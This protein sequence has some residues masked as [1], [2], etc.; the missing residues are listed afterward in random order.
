[1]G[2]AELEM[3]IR[4]INAEIGRYNHDIENVIKPLIERLKQ[5]K[6]NIKEQYNKYKNKI[7]GDIGVIQNTIWYAQRKSTIYL[8]E[9]EINK[10][11]IDEYIRKIDDGISSADS[12]RMNTG[13]QINNLNTEISSLNNE[14]A[15]IRDE[16][17]R[18]E[19]AR[20]RLVAEL[21]KPRR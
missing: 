9:L 1:M 13:L 20:L 2:I 17:A 4:D 6:E 19:A 7:D 10:N 12:T 21:N 5:N 3:R 14:I 18:A 15:R 16:E 11:T 8:N